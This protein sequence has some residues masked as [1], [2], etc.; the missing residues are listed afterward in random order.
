MWGHDSKYMLGQTSHH[1]TLLIFLWH[2]NFWCDYCEEENP[3]SYFF[4]KWS[5]FKTIHLGKQT[6]QTIPPREERENVSLAVC[7]LF[8]PQTTAHDFCFSVY[9]HVVSFHCERLPITVLVR[10]GKELNSSMV[11]LFN[12]DNHFFF[13]RVMDKSA[14]KKIQFG[15]KVT[16]T[17]IRTH[18]ILS[19]SEFLKFCIYF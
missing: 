2:T 13:G 17:W 16:K 8:F 4:L 5:V 15:G 7:F 18:V 6:M 9:C 11:Q 1:W 19:I 3:R 10:E 12:Q 14:E